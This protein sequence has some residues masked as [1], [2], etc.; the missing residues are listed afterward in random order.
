MILIDANIFMYAA[1]AEHPHKTPSVDLL[2]RV[3]L[4]E[5]EAAVDAEVLQEILHRYRAIRRWEDGREVY[6]LARRIVPLVV[7][8]TDQIVD[9]ARD[10][11]D[12]DPRISA[13]DALHAAAALARG[14]DAICSYD[15]DLDQIV[16]LRR[17]EPPAP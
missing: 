17:I 1:G 2:R 9:R 5:I 13:R 12:D 14:M 16:G 7:A 4:G 11:L 3:A 10:L 15:R 6:A 8:I